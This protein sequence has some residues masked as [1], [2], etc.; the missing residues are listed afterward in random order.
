MVGNCR[1]AAAAAVEHGAEG[2]LVTDWGDNGHL[3]YLPVS[4]P[5]FAYGAAVSWCVE[6]NEAIDLETALS[7][8]A[9]ADPSGGIAAA[10]HLLGDAHRLVTPQV[11]NNSILAFHLYR[12]RFRM[13][14]GITEGMTD[15][16]LA[17]VVS[18]IDEARSLLASSASG[19]DDAALVV[20][21]LDTSARLL[22]LLV[23]DAR[24]RLAAGGTLEAV[25]ADTRRAFAGELDTL[26]EEHRTRWLARNRPG[27]LADSTSRL[28]ALRAAY[29]ED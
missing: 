24:E 29:G 4:E 11:P 21:E 7:V 18:A 8:H 22:S 28:E 26:I 9:F 17:R 20:A 23:R 25:D 12:P 6:A 5:G 14:E 1:G 15:G 13:G 16:D 10:L 27:G 3:Q 2:Y 19:R